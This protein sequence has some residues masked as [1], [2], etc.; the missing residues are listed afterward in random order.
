MTLILWKGSYLLRIL[1]S[2]Y[3]TLATIYGTTVMPIAI[4]L[5][6]TNCFNYMLIRLN[7]EDL[8][9]D[10]P[11]LLGARLGQVYI[12]IKCTT[13]YAISNWFTHSPSQYYRPAIPFDSYLSLRPTNLSLNLSFVAH[14]SYSA[15]SLTAM[16]GADRS[17][18]TTYHQVC[19]PM[20][21][22]T[23]LAP[24]LTLHTP[25]YISW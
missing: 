25:W 18:S 15:C 24:L 1:Y 12:M 21:I 16:C 3:L 5:Y 22:H 23:I 10:L 19:T 13:I 17:R 2:D 14:I 20:H 7:R 9:D 4:T 11:K 8:G 6:T